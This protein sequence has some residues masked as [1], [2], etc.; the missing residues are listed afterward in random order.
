MSIINSLFNV[1]GHTFYLACRLDGL[2]PGGT[3]GN[4]SAD[5]LAC[6]GFLRAVGSCTDGSSGER[7]PVVKPIPSN[8]TAPLTAL[9]SR[10]RNALVSDVAEQQ[11]ESSGAISQPQVHK[12]PV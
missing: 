5:C 10:G 2:S 3:I 11:R 9:P 1:K 8:G 6:K 12:W 7:V 4:Y